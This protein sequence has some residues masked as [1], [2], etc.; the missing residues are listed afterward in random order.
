M[1]T[2]SNGNQLVSTT[3]AQTQETDWL[4]TMGQIAVKITSQFNGPNGLLSETDYNRLAVDGT[5]R[6][7]A[8]KYQFFNV[9]TNFGCSGI[10]QY[11]ASNVGLV[12]EIDLPN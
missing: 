1:S 5:Y 8:V 2:D 7:I 3:N 6:S 4:D 9:Q 11:S 12:S 10:A